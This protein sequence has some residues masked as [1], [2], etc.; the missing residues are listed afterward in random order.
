MLIERAQIDDLPAVLDVLDELAA[1]LQQRG[2][3]QWPIKFSGEGDWREER[4]RSYV[5]DG[6]CWL[7]RADDG[8]VAATFTTGGPDPHFAHGWP[9]D[10]DKGLYVYRMAV[11]R[12]YAGHSMGTKI[13][14]WCGGRAAALGYD[15]LRLDCH[16]KNRE[17]QLYYEEHGFE[18]VDTVVHTMP[19]GGDG[20]PYTRGSG[21]LYQRPAGSLP[22]SAP[23]APADRYDPAGT[24]AIWDQAAKAVLDLKLDQPLT[25]ENAWNSALD[26][27][28]FEL[29]RR[30]SEVRQ[31]N[32]AYY[33]V[34]DGRSRE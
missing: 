31:L 28:S 30:S 11:R 29:G 21:A 15:W 8:E 2:I 18:H 22:A 12:K 1:W 14:D 33:R 32:G 25:N 23:E 16:R 17:L 19:D 24:G 6:E 10:P 20:E 13:L 3:T 4:L 34:L 26:Q 27:A 7:V 5:E 9:D